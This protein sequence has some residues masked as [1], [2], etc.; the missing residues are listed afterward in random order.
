MR[1]EDLRTGMCVLMRS[2]SYGIVMGNAVLSINNSKSH[3][4]GTPLRNYNDELDYNT[5]KID[6]MWD[7]MEVYAEKSDL[8]GGSILLKTE[9][10]QNI[11]DFLLGNKVWV[12]ATKKEMTIRELE[13]KLGYSIKIVGEK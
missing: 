7:I 4:G 6:H 3:T 12:R 1:K 10:T 8:S 2:G 9:S 13:D 5:N 11:K